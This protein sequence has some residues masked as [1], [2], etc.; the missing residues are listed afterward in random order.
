MEE[1]QEIK[2]IFVAYKGKFLDTS[3]LLEEL[4]KRCPENGKVCYECR[5][6][7][8]ETIFMGKILAKRNPDPNYMDEPYFDPYY[9]VFSVGAVDANDLK[10]CITRKTSPKVHSVSTDIYS[11]LGAKMYQEVDYIHFS[12]AMF[13]TAKRELIAGVTIPNNDDNHLF[14][15][16]TKSIR[17]LVFSNSKDLLKTVCD[18][19]REMNNKSYMVNGK[20]VEFTPMQEEKQKKLV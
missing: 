15:G 11:I 20:L 7:G 9:D 17:E 12:S 3:V 10:T 13:D 8:G 6:F 14:Y 2:P 18:V 19:T 1:L 4:N 16:Y 5:I